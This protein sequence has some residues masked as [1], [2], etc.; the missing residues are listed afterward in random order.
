MITGKPWARTSPK[1]D[2]PLSE[3]AP[4]KRKEILDFF[5]SVYK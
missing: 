1:S 3:L 5:R 2:K 4:E